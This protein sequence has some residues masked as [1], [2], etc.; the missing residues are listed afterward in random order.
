MS[1]TE[2]LTIVYAVPKSRY[3]AFATDPV[4]P[5]LDS[6]ELANIVT[7]VHVAVDDE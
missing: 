4:N 5:L 1:A 7:I 2:H 6:P 3:N